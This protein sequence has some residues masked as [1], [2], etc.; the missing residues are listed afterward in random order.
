MVSGRYP[1]LQLGADTAV[2]C[3]H[4]SLLGVDISSD[5]SLDH[6]ISVSARAAA[7]DFVNCVVSGSHW[8]PTRWLCRC[9]FMDWVFFNLAVTVHWCMS[10]HAPLSDCVAAAGADT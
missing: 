8:T 5:L 9:E 3:S 1:V 10:G 7:I 4:V 2:V 6:H